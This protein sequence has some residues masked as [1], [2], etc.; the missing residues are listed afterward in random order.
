MTRIKV[1]VSTSNE[2]RSTRTRF[3]THMFQVYRERKGDRHYCPS[4]FRYGEYVVCSWKNNN[5][6]RYAFCV[7][8]VGR[9]NSCVRVV[10]INPCKIE[11]HQCDNYEISYEIDRSASTVYRGT[12]T[13]ECC[14]RGQILH[15]IQYKKRPGRRRGAQ[16]FFPV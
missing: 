10:G 16:R 12:V 6:Q 3:Q 7:F 8:I 5:N 2:F 14:N 1:R 15:S 13:N 11:T 9:D 4:R